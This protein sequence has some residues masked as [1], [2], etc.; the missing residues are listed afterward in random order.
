MLIN[1]IPL[2]FVCVFLSFHPCSCSPLIFPPRLS[3]P[4][5]PLPLGLDCGALTSARPPL[6]PRPPAMASR[7]GLRMQ[8]RHIPTSNIVH[9]TLSSGKDILVQ[10][11]CSVVYSV[12][13]GDGDILVS[14]IHLT[15][16][17]FINH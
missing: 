1:T 13:I 8:V 3:S 7:I 14:I 17:T 2:C 9:A 5:L 11:V 10:S 12:D 6:P 4:K 16:S 15:A